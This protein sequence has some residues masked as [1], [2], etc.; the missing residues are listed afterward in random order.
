MDEPR[1]V[2]GTD[3]KG[4]AALCGAERLIEYGALKDPEQHG[5]R[6]VDCD[7]S[8]I[9]AS[10][11]NA[12]THLYSG[13]APLGM[14]PASPE[15]R[16]FTEILERVWWKLD[17]ALDERSLRAA[18]RYYVAH[19]LL[20]GTS[21]LVDHH[22]SPGFIEG[23]LDVLA[24]V[25]QELG[26]RAVLCYGATERNGSTA[27][28]RRGLGECKR[29]IE[30]NDR[31]LIRGMV[32]LHASFTVGDETIRDAGNLARE[33]ETSLHVHVA[34]AEEDVANARLRGYPGP[35]ER[36][37]AL[38]ALIPRSILA[39]G[40]HLSEAQ[41]E[42]A[43]EA[44]CW[45]VQ[46]P[47]SNAGNGVGFPFALVR[48]TRV[49]LGTDGY[50]SN[51]EEELQGLFAS[52]RE[53]E[54]VTDDLWLRQQNGHAILME[55]WDYA[56]SGLVAGA[57]PDLCVLHKDRTLRHLV[58]GGELVVE[59]GELVKGDL[60]EIEREAQECAGPLW[61]RMRAL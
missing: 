60:E 42:L 19:A 1:L 59:D 45:F 36:L 29:F 20:S 6:V 27:E 22:E 28:A 13:L 33:L 53:H 38:G 44:D 43:T 61:E 21:A 56:R 41:V 46:N 50:P 31:P 9:G 8:W 58:V 25:C 14:P 49:A 4:H 55:R 57:L 17:R 54:L 7:D 24:D 12:H 10:F 18:A 51:P 35:L 3:A 48:A 11:V 34:E 15:P 47:R 5:V 52:A 40:V 2:L 37:L 23:S 39:H 16:C 30:S 26:M 32:G